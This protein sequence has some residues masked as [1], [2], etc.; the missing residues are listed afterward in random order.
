MARK[1]EDARGD[2]VEEVSVMR[3][4][5]DPAGVILE[6]ALEP[7]DH[8]D[9][10]VVRRLVEEEEVRLAQERLRQADARLLAAGEMRDVLLKV[11]LC[12]AEAE[13]HAADAALVVVAAEQFEALDDLA[14]GAHRLLCVVDGNLLLERLLALAERDD[15]VKGA[16]ELLVERPCAEV[17]LLLD[18]ADSRR[19]IELYRAAVILL[20]AEQAAHER[21]LAGTICPDKADLVAARDLETDIVEELVDAE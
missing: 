15:I 14:V 6:E 2:A 12:E 5:Q 7:L 10:E 20:L 1:L 9:V 4:D 16:Q 8:V 17:G 19:L 3:D 11:L 18:I 21:R 13:G